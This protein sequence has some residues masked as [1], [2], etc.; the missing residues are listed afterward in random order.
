MSEAERSSLG[1]AKKGGTKVKDGAAAAAPA[2]LS[3][4]APRERRASAKTDQNEWKHG[5]YY[6]CSRPWTLERIFLP[7][8][9]ISFDDLSVFLHL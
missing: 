9:S 8:R 1:R 5:L 6:I 2:I 4:R 3:R 7:P